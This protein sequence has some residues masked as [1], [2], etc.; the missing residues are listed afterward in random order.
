MPS[1][2]SSAQDLRITVKPSEVTFL[3]H[4]GETI[5]AAALRAEVLL[6]HSCQDGAC[7]SCKCLRLAGEVVQG[8]HQ[9]KALSLHEQQQ[10]MVLTCCAFAHSD[11]VLESPQVGS[12]GPMRVRKLPARV[13]TMQRKSQDVMLLSLQLP[14]NDGLI[15]R[16]GQYDE[17][18]LANGSQRSY[19]MANAPGVGACVLEFHVRHRPGGRFTDAL[20]GTMKEG[21]IVRIEG[22]YGSFFL[23]EDSDRPIIFLA[24]G[25]GL[26]P[27]KAIIEHMHSRGM[28]RPA[29]LYWG[30][31]RPHDLYLE[32]WINEQLAAMPQLRYVPVVS[33]ALAQDAWQGRTGFVHLAVLEDF[34]D[35]SRHQVYAC[36]APVM[37]EAARGAFLQAGLP[38]EQFF[39]DAFT[40]EADQAN[41]SKASET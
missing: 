6:P 19:S 39:A 25:T 24:S 16:P 21:D 22:P 26:A 10:G 33:D 5:L 37:V 1:K 27:I 12:G 36:G 8:T 38:S 30:G 7:G 41:T 31:Y 17:V 13:R 11:V 2:E 9:S 15:Y 14:A 20:F 18:K 34:A 29:V 40:T 23:R 32:P 35:L 4:R 3:A 28:K